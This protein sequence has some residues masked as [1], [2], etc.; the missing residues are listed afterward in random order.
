MLDTNIYGWYL[1]YTL[2]GERNSEAINSFRLISRLIEDKNKEKKLN[3]EKEDCEILAAVTMS[4]T[5][6]FVTENRLT[7]NNP[8]VK[9]IVETVNSNRNLQMPRILSSEETIYEIF[10]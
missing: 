6:W 8:I 9:K 10:V 3:I 5:K 1:A 2:K 4:R 7:I